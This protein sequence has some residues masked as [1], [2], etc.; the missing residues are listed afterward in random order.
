[1]VYFSIDINFNEKGND[2]LP[3]SSLNVRGETFFS[4]YDKLRF[5]MNPFADIKDV[6]VW[7]MGE[8]QGNSFTLNYERYSAEQFKKMVSKEFYKE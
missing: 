4:A 2:N 3:C 7:Y 5:I 8:T 1:M 6:Y